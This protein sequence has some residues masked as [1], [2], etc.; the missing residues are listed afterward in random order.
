MHVCMC[1]CVLVGVFVQ[2]SMEVRDQFYVTPQTPPTLF[3]E[4]GFFIGLDFAS[5]PQDLP[6]FTSPELGL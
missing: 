3:F 5:K 4:T 1:E 6:A 2:V